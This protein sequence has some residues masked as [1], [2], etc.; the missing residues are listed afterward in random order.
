VH[1]FGFAVP[2]GGVNQAGLLRRIREQQLHQDP[3]A[4]IRLLNCAGESQVSQLPL[5]LPGATGDATRIEHDLVDNSLPIQLERRSPVS[6]D[7]RIVGDEQQAD[8]ALPLELAPFEHVRRGVRLGGIS[9]AVDE[10]GTTL[11]DGSGVE[12]LDPRDVGVA[13]THIRRR[14]P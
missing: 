10:V 9:I 2:F 8:L 5:H 13:M 1:A 6:G 11:M 14:S 12:L 7:V 3:A 4:E